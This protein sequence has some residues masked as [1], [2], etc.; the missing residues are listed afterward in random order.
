MASHSESAESTIPANSRIRLKGDPTRIGVVT[1]K[2]RP[3]R[4]GKDVRLQVTFPDA[5]SWIPSDQV[6]IIPTQQETPIDLLQAGKLGRALDFRRTLTHMRLTGRLADVIYSMEATN[7]DFYSYQFK[8]V[9]RFLMSPTN[10]MLIA[11][12]VG[13]GKTIEAGLIWTELKSRFDYRRLLVLC[14]AI[15]REKWEREL[16]NK[17]GVR[18]EIVDA[19]L[20]HKR[21]VNPAAALEGFA[22]ISSIQG[23]RPHR[24]WENTD[25]PNSAARLARLFRDKE[26]EEPLVDLL[27]VDEAHY[28]RNPE[29]QTNELGRLAR[30]ITENLLLL[31]ATPIHNYSQD[32]F[33]LLQLLDPDTFER[34]D[35]LN[36]I[37]QSSRPLVEA[38][39]AILSTAPSRKKIAELIDQASQHPL[40]SG[41]RQLAVAARQLAE[42]TV[43]DDRDK[44]AKLARKLETVNPLA[45]VITRTRKRDVK[46]WRVIREPVP[47]KIPMNSFE[48]EFYRAVTDRV[49]SYAMM[50]DA[51]TRFLLANPQRQMSSSMAGTLRAWKKKRD[52]LDDASDAAQNRE[53][54][55][56]LT[57]ELVNDAEELGNIEELTANDSKYKRVL[58]NL[59]S[60][61][62]DY[63]AEKVV[64]FSTFRE[65]L[66]YLGERLEE[67]GITNL[68]MHGGVREPKDTLLSRFESDPDVRILLSS[69]VG[70][71]GVDLQFCRLL[72]NYD[73][74]WNPMR[75]EQR[76]GRLDRLG[77]LAKKIIIW[78]LF[79]DKTIDSR[80]YTRL[81]DK[82]DLCREALGD[83]E[84]VLG[85]EIRKLTTDLLSDHLSANEQDLRIDQTA[86]ALANL[87]QE[88]QNLENE[89]SHL[90]AYGDYILNQ[91]QAA[92]ELNRWIDGSDLLAY[93]KDFF[94]LH[95]PGCSFQRQEGQDHVLDIRLSNQA[96][97]DLDQFVRDNRLHTTR[98][99]QNSSSPVRC[100]FENRITSHTHGVIEDITQFH[101]VV[102]FVSK[103][104][105]A[106]EEQLRPAVSIRLEQSTAGSQ[107]NKGTYIL[108]VARWS[109]EGLQAIEKL[110][111]SAAMIG[112]N[113][114]F[115]D[116][117][118]S[119]RLSSLCSQHASDWFEA[120]NVL[121]IEHCVK[122]AD[123]SLFAQLEDRFEAFVDDVKRQNEDRADLQLK[124]LRRHLKN[125]RRK[126]EQVREGHRLCGRDSLV[127]ATEGRIAALENRIHR[128][129]LEIENRRKVR[130]HN[131]EVLVAI[132]KIE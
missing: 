30:G 65:T 51:N 52:N 55:G 99:T 76:I 61:F 1:G 66:N 130:Y 96:K 86:Q 83:F 60:Y 13:L 47:E 114:R 116:E 97:Q 126:L 81:Y 69:E 91:V 95:Y 119:E 3:G 101:P 110:A 6:E 124:T 94:G 4:R 82:L 53:R 64:L 35:D 21:L 39:D 46:E 121:D 37:L 45:Y 70:S 87:K 127:K 25:K 73:L 118:D 131:D 56:P 44:R 77:Q 109:V 92:R 113:K 48:T 103:S 79:Y 112:D 84:A 102:R 68:I 62:N 74:P 12:E 98:L 100:R 80:I 129:E 42:N 28:L 40:L 5:T 18:A 108:C 20:L 11:D 107:I 33:S 54:L 36:L 90:V 29:S 123:G 14:P 41:N 132:V 58:D 78:N 23:A 71:E 38:R 24:D 88:N 34:L 105:R 16:E 10:A 93:V 111:Y 125:Q 89:A 122:I 57:T 19:K 32:L 128:K 9:L 67:D 59:K 31:S 7:T 8:P 120:K 106:K 50:Q 22:L 15:L 117:A 85:D 26:Q 49:V 27:I 17:I 2:T 75:V 104:I 72:I 43:F 115:L 63:P